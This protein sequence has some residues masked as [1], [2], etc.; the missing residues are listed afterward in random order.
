MLQAE[1]HAQQSKTVKKNMD[2]FRVSFS[3]RPPSRYEHSG[4]RLDQ[5]SILF[6][7]ASENIPMSSAHSWKTWCPRYFFAVWFFHNQEHH[8]PVHHSWSTNLD[9][10]VFDLRLF[11]VR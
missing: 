10:H 9:M 7:C 11:S 6:A 3:A 2:E 1:E 4:L 5:M 8:W